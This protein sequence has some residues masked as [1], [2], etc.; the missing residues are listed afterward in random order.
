MQLLLK[1]IGVRLLQLKLRKRFQR[2]VLP[3]PPPVPDKNI[4]P[5]GRSGP[6]QFGER[7][8]LPPKNRLPGVHMPFRL[9]PFIND[10]ILAIVI[11]GFNI[12]VRFLFKSIRDD[13]QIKELESHTLQAELN[14]LKAQINPHFFMNTLNNIHA[15]IDIDTGKAKDTVIELSKIM[16]YVL[17]DADQSKVSLTKEILFLNNYIDLMRIRFVDNI[18][19]LTL[20]LEEIQDVETPPLLLI[21]LIENAF[22]HGVGFEKNS[23]IHTSLFIEDD[24]LH[25]IVENSISFEV[26]RPSGAGLENLRKRLSLLFGKDYLLNITRDPEKYKVQLIIPFDI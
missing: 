3:F 1:E 12:A 13:R 18:D 14:Y 7:R 4:L 5:E 21:T 23:Y 6:P 8:F 22:K 25:Y 17:Y 2:S 24:K 19:I 9:I 15:L 26:H 16:R 10:W 11:I 20:Y